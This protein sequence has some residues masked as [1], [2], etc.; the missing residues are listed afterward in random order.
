[1]S[2]EAPQLGGGWLLGDG[3]F[4]TCR[5][6]RGQTLLEDHH[7]LRLRRSGEALGFAPELIE[8]GVGQIQ[9]LAERR[10]GLW[11]VT[12]VRGG[13]VDVQ[14]RPVPARP[15]PRLMTLRGFYFPGDELGEHKTLSWMRSAEGLR[16]AREAGFDEAIRLSPDGQV[17]EACAGNV[18]VLGDDGSWVTPVVDGLLPGVY[19]EAFLEL[20]RTVGVEIE[21]RVVWE[22]ELRRARAVVLTSAGRLFQGAHSLDGREFGGSAG[23]FVEVML[24]VLLKDRLKV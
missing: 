3:L 5:V 15:S 11:R 6:M 24:E 9:T 13:E 19:R 20:S 10:E 4:E 18:F 17:G 7:I 16:R 1:M 22:E 12:V 2:L 23:E 14:Y 8:A 21:E